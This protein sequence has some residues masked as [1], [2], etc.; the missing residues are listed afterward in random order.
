VT[1][2]RRRHYPSKHGGVKK[3]VDVYSVNGS[4]RYDNA[5]NLIKKSKA[6]EC[7]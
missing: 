6:G 1:T 4:P 7:V 2:L 3:A 5:G